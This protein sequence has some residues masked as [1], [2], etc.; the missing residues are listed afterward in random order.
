MLGG[1]P[2]RF[3]VIHDLCISSRLIFPTFCKLASE[4][5]EG[6]IGFPKH[7]PFSRKPSEVAAA[8]LATPSG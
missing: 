6:S 7:H 5:K 8:L 4:A 2:M 1:D 3:Y